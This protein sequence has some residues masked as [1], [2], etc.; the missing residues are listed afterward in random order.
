M[1]G[2]CGL[3]GK[4]K[5]N[6][7]DAIYYCCFT[8]SYF[9]IADG[10][11]I[12][13]DKDGFRLEAFF[14][15]QGQDQKV[16]CINR[17]VN[18]KEFSLNGIP[19]EKFSKHIGLLPAVMIAPDDIELITGK[20]ENRRR[21]IDTVLSQV[22]AG[23][24]QELIIYNK[25]LQQ[26]NSLL[27]KMDED[28]EGSR[29]VLEILDEQLIAPGNTIHGKRTEFLQQLLPLVQRFYH[30]IADNAE[31]ISLSYLSQLNDGLLKNC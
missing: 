21:Y 3:N 28:K 13:F 6:L 26:R 9:S 23:Y 8:K 15:K 1:V 5:T 18:K 29:T 19:Y 10:F 30:M 27:K 14:A 31:N 20:S 22:D 11:N 12:N 4:G 24:L 16:I 25:V 17:A 2:I 7:L